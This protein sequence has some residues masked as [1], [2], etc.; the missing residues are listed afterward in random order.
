M[1]ELIT[2]IIVVLAIALIAG[3]A[4]FYIVRE[5]RRGNACIG[6]PHAKL[7][8]RGKGGCCGSENATEDGESR[9]SNK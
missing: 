3:G 7:C 6:C 1:P 5:K 4:T 9:D 8:K 2:N